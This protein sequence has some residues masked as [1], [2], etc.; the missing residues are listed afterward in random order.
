MARIMS[1]S[2][3]LVEGSTG[4]KFSEMIVMAL[5]VVGIFMGVRAYLD[6]RRGPTFAL[7][8]FMGAVKS[9]NP[10]N[11]YSLIDELDKKGRFPPLIYEKNTL[12]HGYTERIENS[13]FSPEI[14]GSDPDRVTIPMVTTIRAGSSGKQLYETGQKETYSDKIVMRKNKDGHWRVVLSASVDKNTGKLELQKA[15][16]SP[17]GF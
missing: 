4:V 6:Y 7:S 10:Q 9:G 5:A 2:R 13:A 12:C 1:R 16:P 17:E 15:T 8:E 11:Q 3:P 14:K